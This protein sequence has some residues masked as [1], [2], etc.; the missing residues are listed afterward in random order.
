[1]A[2][3]PEAQFAN[4]YGPTETNVITWYRV[5]PLPAD[6]DDP[7]PIGRACANTDLLIVADDGALVSEPGREGELYARGPT[8]AQGYWGDPERSARGFVT[9]PFQPAFA[10]R[11]YRTGD[12]VVLQPDGSLLFLGRRDR[13]V[14]SRG[15]RI[16]L[17]EIETVLYQHPQVKEV[18]VVAVPD[19]V[20]GSRIRAFLACAE[21]GDGAL[22]AIREHCAARLPRYMVPESFE[23]L[24]ELPKTST[25][26]LDRTALAARARSV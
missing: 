17:D 22:A 8:V 10:E 11:V 14:K 16:E 6:R 25:G 2:A 15:Y 12:I 19:E 26:K 23:L 21:T 18:A 7:I 5:P 4:L 1:M 3:L 9:N 20:V 24:A 13:M